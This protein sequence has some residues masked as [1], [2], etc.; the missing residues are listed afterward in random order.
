MSEIDWYVN[1][2][3]CEHE[4]VRHYALDVSDI[5]CIFHPRMTRLEYRPVTVP[6]IIYNAVAACELLL[7]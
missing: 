1:C 6:K 7:M 4:A 3:I 5:C 2:D